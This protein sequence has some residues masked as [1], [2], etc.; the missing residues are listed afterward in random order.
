MD[1][2]GVVEEGFRR[3]GMDNAD[4]VE[5]DHLVGDPDRVRELLGVHGGSH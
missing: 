2:L 3:P 1:Q 5:D 4:D